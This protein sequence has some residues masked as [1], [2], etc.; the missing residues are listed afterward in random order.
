MKL[1]DLEST[2][3]D[4]HIVNIVVNEKDWRLGHRLNRNEHLQVVARLGGHIPDV[5]L[6]ALL[7]ISGDVVL[8]MRK[9]VAHD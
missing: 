4:W 2:E 6:A 9:R 7:G 8:K 1:A 3:I 5:E